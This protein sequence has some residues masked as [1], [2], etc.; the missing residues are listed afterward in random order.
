MRVLLFAGLAEA[1]GCRELRWP[2]EGFASD[3]ASA[4]AEGISAAELEAALRAAHPA[5]QGRRFRLAVNQRYVGP[6]QFVAAT[7]E[8]ALIPPVSGG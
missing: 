1:L 7:D 5:L 2:S 6:E 3:S 8:V 4:P